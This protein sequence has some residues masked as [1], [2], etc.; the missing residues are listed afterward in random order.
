MIREFLSKSFLEKVENP[1]AI[2]NGICYDI[3][4]LLLQCGHDHLQFST[5]NFFRPN[6]DT[7]I[8]NPILELRIRSWW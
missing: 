4:G 1:V 2:P 7:Q 3:V 6:A 8:L 5:D